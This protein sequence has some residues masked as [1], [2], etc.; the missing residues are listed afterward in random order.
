MRVLWAPLLPLP[1]RDPGDMFQPPQG[2][3]PYVDFEA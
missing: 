3:V 2:L 1:P